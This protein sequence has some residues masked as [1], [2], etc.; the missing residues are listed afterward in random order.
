[1]LREEG[2]VVEEAKANISTVQTVLQVFV[3]SG[4]WAFLDS[5][6]YLYVFPHLTTTRL[7]QLCGPRHMGIEKQKPLNLRCTLASPTMYIKIWVI[8]CW[9]S[10]TVTTVTGTQQGAPNRN[11]NCRVVGVPHSSGGGDGYEQRKRDAGKVSQSKRTYC[12]V[13][14]TMCWLGTSQ[15]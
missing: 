6:V 1:M 2:R 7:E 9:N 11:L 5:T 3:G 14:C 12:E 4:C 15:R 8:W 13:G 10:N